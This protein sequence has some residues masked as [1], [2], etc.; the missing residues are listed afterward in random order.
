MTDY[1]YKD[2]FL[3]AGGETY[4]DVPSGEFIPRGNIGLAHT[5]RAWGLTLG[6]SASFDDEGEYTNG[7][8]RKVSFS[9]T[10]IRLWLRGGTKEKANEYV[11][12]YLG[13]TRF[14]TPTYITTM[15]TASVTNMT[16]ETRAKFSPTISGE[17]EVVGLPKDYQNAKHAAGLSLVAIPSVVNAYALGRGWYTD[18]LF[19]LSLVSGQ[20]VHSDT[21]EQIEKLVEQRKAL[22]GALGEKA[23]NWRVNVPNKLESKKL[24]EAIAR[25]V[26]EDWGPSW[27]RMQTVHNPSP[28]SYYTQEKDVDGKITTVAKRN[29]VQTIIEFFKNERE[30]QEVGAKELAAQDKDSGTTENGSGAPDLFDALS[31]GAKK[32]Y[33]NSATFAS[34]IGDIRQS[35]ASGKA[36]KLVMSEWQLTEADFELLK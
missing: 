29:Y 27:L 15:A 4:G 21:K 30:A 32:Q 7:K 5:F 14:V 25:L 26:N 20:E 1:K 2:D 35:I 18:N 31:D 13:D 33:G 24:A 3:T 9:T 12:H 6:K 19:D 17:C 8:P 22:W 36:K 16:D 10:G 34:L 28:G 23:E 11:K